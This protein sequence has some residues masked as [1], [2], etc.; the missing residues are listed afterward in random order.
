MYSLVLFKFGAVALP[1]AR[2]LSFSS[3]LGFY[4]WKL[5]PA[6]CLIRHSIRDKSHSEPLADARAAALSGDFILIVQLF[7]S[8]LFCLMH[9]Q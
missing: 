5:F 3:L 7:L 2:R 1:L 6:R 8:R 4:S 9:E